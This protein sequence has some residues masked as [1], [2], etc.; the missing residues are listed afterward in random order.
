MLKDNMHVQLNGKVQDA[1]NLIV[2]ETSIAGGEM[3]S[4][5]FHINDAIKKRNEC[6]KWNGCHGAIVTLV[7]TFARCEHSHV[8]THAPTATQNR[9]V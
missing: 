3:E 5:S 1:S 8:A 6:T 2:G 9:Q 7:S 4:L